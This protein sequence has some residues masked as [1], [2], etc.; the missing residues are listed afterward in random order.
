MDYASFYW[1]AFFSLLILARSGDV[2][3]TQTDPPLISVVAWL[4]TRLRGARLITWLQ[5]IFPEVAEGLGVLC[6]PL[7]LASLMR[8][9]DRSLRGTQMNVILGER[10]RQRLTAHGIAPGMLRIIPNWA[11]EERIHPVAAEDNPLRRSWGLEGKF[12]VGY[13]G[14]LGRAHEFDT[15][16]GAMEQLR[17]DDRI[18]FA[19]IG[20]GAGMVG[21]ERTV[22]AAGLSNVRFFPYQPRERLS[23]SPSVADVRLVSLRP[24]LEGLIVPSKIYGI[25]AAARPTVFIGDADGEVA[26]LI[27]EWRV[28]FTVPVGG[29]GNFV[30][31]LWRLKD[32]R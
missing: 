25:L 14:N 26:R 13:S 31:C 16:V 11:D 8:I 32:D 30:E 20:G 18:V 2:I 7:W 4:A 23:E 19:F 6:R 3:V 15:M 10:M 12:V 29:V 1:S 28:G 9:R 5:D 27:A 21:L 22:A 17:E 24:Q